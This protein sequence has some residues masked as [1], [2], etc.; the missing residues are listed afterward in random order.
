M[1]SRIANWSSVVVPPPRLRLS[2][3]SPND[4]GI[5]TEWVSKKLDSRLEGG[6]GGGPEAGTAFP[7]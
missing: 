2:L 3:R 6:C 7:L 1:I 5:Q 4:C